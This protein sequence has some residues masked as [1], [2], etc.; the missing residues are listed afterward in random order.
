MRKFLTICAIA[1]TFSVLGLAETWN[2]TLLDATCIQRHSGTKSC[3]AKPATM[4]Y[5]L[6]VSG[7]R[8][9]LDR[10]SNERAHAAMESRADR[11]SNPDATKATPVTAKVTGRIKTDGKI[12]ADV[13][14]VQ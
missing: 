3:D 14:E 5:L 7:T 4:T 8:Y 1:G 9:K 2:G 13:I 12:H 6:D 11:A 10:A